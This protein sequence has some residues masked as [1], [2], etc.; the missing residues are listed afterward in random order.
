MRR[1]STATLMRWR[2]AARIVVMGG[3]STEVNLGLNLTKFH[4]VG[5]G[6]G[7]SAAGRELGVF[8]HAAE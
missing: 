6:I 8:K 7:A 4:L 2:G 5:G 1:S 3:Q